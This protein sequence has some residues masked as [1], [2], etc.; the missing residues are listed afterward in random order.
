MLLAAMHVF[1]SLWKPLLLS[2]VVTGAVRDG[3]VQTG[4]V[5]GPL[6]P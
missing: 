5:C 6:A 1:M 3:E 2:A 4:D